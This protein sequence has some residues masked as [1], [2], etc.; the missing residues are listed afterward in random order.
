M[1]EQYGLPVQCKYPSEPV[2]SPITEVGPLNPLIHV[3]KYESQADRERPREPVVSYLPEYLGKREMFSV[4]EKL[5]II[6]G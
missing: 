1:Y 3:W 5:Q 2:V 4:W 6:G